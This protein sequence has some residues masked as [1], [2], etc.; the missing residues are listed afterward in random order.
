MNGQTGAAFPGGGPPPGG[1]F[2]G[3]SGGPPG[4]GGPRGGLFMLQPWLLAVVV[5]VGIAVTVVAFWQI[6]RKAGYSGA[7]G[8]LMFVPVVNIAAMLW[9]AFTEWPVIRQL[10]EARAIAAAHMTPEGDA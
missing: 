5:I 4:F 10:R 6:Y 2:P 7:L 8:L 3:G 9:L 1:A